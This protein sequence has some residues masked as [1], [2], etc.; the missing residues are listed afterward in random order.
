MNLN[1]GGAGSLQAAIQ[2]ATAMAG[3]D[4]IV[5][6]VSGTIVLAAN[7]PGLTDD[8]THI[9]GATAPDTMVG[10][11]IV[12]DCAA[13]GNHGLVINGATGCWIQ[14][15][16][17]ENAPLFG[18]NVIGGAAGNLIG[19]SGAREGN[20]LRLNNVGLRLANP[21]TDG[22]TA[23]QNHIY[24]NVLDGVGIVDGSSINRIGGVLAGERNLIFGNGASGVYVYSPLAS[25]NFCNANVIEGNSI[26]TDV[27]GAAAMPNGLHGVYIREECMLTEVR[28]N[29][30][31]FNGNDG[32][33][34]Q[35]SVNNH[36]S[37]NVCSGNLGNG[38]RIG[39]GAATMETSWKTT[40]S[41]PIR[42]GWRLFRMESTGSRSWTA[43]LSTLLPRTRFQ[44]TWMTGSISMALVRRTTTSRKT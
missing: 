14:G 12:L 23:Y 29:Y 13:I 5:F 27:G 34:I 40:G 39:P 9:L 44:G 30:V 3:A 36:V 33:A 2:N 32:I 10:P 16:R 20:H 35:V 24:D 43:R 18:I 41:A 6:M 15:V 8:G 4:D 28:E 1:N 31:M 42:L 21:G 26:G 19:G 25:G 11:D 38:V 22:N 17:I 37:G 7:L